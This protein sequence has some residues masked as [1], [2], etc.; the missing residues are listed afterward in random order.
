MA[1]HLPAAPPPLAV[2]AVRRGLRP[3]ASEGGVGALVRAY[4]FSAIICSFAR[5]ITATTTASRRHI[6]ASPSW[7]FVDAAARCSSPPRRFV[8]SAA[9]RLSRLAADERGSVRLTLLE[10]PR[11]RPLRAFAVIIQGPIPKNGSRTSRSLAGACQ[12][13]RSLYQRPAAPIFGPPRFLPRRPTYPGD[14]SS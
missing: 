7:S 11:S 13:I 12:C 2:G 8:T 3:A 4:P 6:Y 5:S 9:R 10:R 1:W 14:S